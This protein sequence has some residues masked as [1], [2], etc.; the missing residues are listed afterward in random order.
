MLP[1]TLRHP[2]QV[3]AA[4]LAFGAMSAPWAGA[5]GSR[6]DDMRVTLAL[7]KYQLATLRMDTPAIVALFTPDATIAHESQTPIAGRDSMRRFFESFAT[8]N[9]RAYTMIVTS[10]NV[11]GDSASQTGTYD[12][13]VRTPDGKQAHVRGTFNAVWARQSDKRW[14]LSRMR[15]ASRP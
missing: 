8:Y 3:A 12:Q 1:P 14:M 5:Q 7:Q 11:V 6:E 9:V 13:T 4:V 10:Q 2:L 15:T